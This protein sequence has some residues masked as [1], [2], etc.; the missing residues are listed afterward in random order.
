MKIDKIWIAQHPTI[1]DEKKVAFEKPN[2]LA[3]FNTHTTKTFTAPFVEYDLIE[4]DK[5]VIK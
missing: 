5:E 2:Y 4:L 1:K 3:F